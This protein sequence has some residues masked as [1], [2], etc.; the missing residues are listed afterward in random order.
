[1]GTSGT[2]VNSTTGGVLPAVLGGP[3]PLAGTDDDANDLQTWGWY[4]IIRPFLVIAK[5]KSTTKPFSNAR[6][7]RRCTRM[8]K[9][10]RFLAVLD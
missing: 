8:K 6:T 4:G 10:Y 7:T 1:M 9:E 2:G 5:K 3:H